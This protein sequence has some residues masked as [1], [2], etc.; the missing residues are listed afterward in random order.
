MFRTVCRYG[1]VGITTIGGAALLLA[2]NGSLPANPLRTA[3]ADVQ[4]MASFSFSQILPWAVAPSP[5]ASTT[6][7]ATASTVVTDVAAAASATLNTVNQLGPLSFDLDSLRSLSAYR[8]Q[9][10]RGTANYTSM[11]QW[12]T[13]IAGV[14]SSA[15][16][17]VS[18][19]TACRTT[20]TSAL[21]PASCR[22]PIDS[23]A[24]LRLERAQSHRLHSSPDRPERGEWPAGQLQFRRHWSVDGRPTRGD[25]QFRNHGLRHLPRLRQ[26]PVYDYRVGGLH[27]TTQVGPATFDF[28]F[29]PYI[30]TGILLPPPSPSGCRQ[31]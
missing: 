27:T 6:G 15:G 1:S 22:R 17:W 26:W 23:A 21:M 4:P 13:G 24:G 20:P 10:H 30:S 12:L 3:G 31:T 7:T 9:Q 29:L 8:D 28:N 18:P 14:G 25:H 19:I 5:S 16:A 11:D 2:A